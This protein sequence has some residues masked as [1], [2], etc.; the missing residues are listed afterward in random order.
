MLPST[1][2]VEFPNSIREL[3]ENPPAEI[4]FHPRCCTRENIIRCASRADLATPAYLKEISSWLEGIEPLLDTNRPQFQ[5][6]VIIKYETLWY[7]FATL[8]IELSRKMPN[9]QPSDSPIVEWSFVQQLMG[10]L[11][12]VEKLLSTIYWIRICRKL[13]NT[14]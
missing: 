3:V 7:I 2:S 8:V 5:K 4:E 6:E 9:R 13:M 1:L 14:F 12:C 11:E 10:Q